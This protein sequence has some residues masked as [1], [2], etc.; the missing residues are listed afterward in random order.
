MAGK[1][2]CFIEGPKVVPK[3]KFVKEQHCGLH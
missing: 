2:Y 3:M 1:V